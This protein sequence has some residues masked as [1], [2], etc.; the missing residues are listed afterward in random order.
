MIQHNEDFLSHWGVYI[1]THPNGKYVRKTD[2]LHSG[3]VQQLDIYLLE[4]W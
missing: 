1:H 2:A 4:P 3:S